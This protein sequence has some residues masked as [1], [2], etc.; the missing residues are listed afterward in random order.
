MLRLERHVHQLRGVADSLDGERRNRLIPRVASDAAE[1]LRVR[2]PLHRQPSQTI[3]GRAFR[4]RTEVP[5]LLEL[6]QRGVSPGKRV[7]IPGGVGVLRE[8]EQP[9]DRLLAYRFVRVLSS[10]PGKRRRIRQ[11]NDGGAPNAL[12]R[13]LAGERSED[14]RRLRRGLV[15]R[16]DGGRAD[17]RVRMLP[18]WLGHETIEQRHLPTPTPP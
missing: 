12:V 3:V 6:R 1:R 5:R 7:G 15:E 14:V 13:I 10:G 16:L 2:Q 17:G 9:L 11:P 8:R 4:D 18:F